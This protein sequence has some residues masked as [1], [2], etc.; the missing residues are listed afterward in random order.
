MDLQ[1]TRKKLGFTQSLTF[2]GDMVPC[3]QFTRNRIG[4]S[5]S[6]PPKEKKCDGDFE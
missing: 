6:F 2:K 1:H 3:E 5:A 4:R